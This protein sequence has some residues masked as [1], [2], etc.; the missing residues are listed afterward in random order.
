MKSRKKILMSLAIVA[1]V[2]VLAATAVVGAVSDTPYERLKA[3]VKTTMT[4]MTK[5]SGNATTVTTIILKD[6][7]TQ[8]FR[9]VES[10][11]SGGGSYEQAKTTWIGSAAAQ[12][13]YSFSSPTMNVYYDASSDTY[14]VT[15]FTDV[16]NVRPDGSYLGGSSS[17][18]S[19]FLARWNDI[20]RIADAFVG[21]LKDYVNAAELGDGGTAFSGALNETQI[22]A[23]ANAIASFAT[24]QMLLSSGVSVGGTVVQPA[25]YDASGAMKDPDGVVDPIPDTP[26]GIP[27]LAGDIFIKSVAG[28]AKTLPSG[29]L[30]DIAVS[31]VLSGTDEDGVIHDLSLDLHV[32]MSDVGTTAVAEPDLTGKKVQ[33]SESNDPYTQNKLTE[34]F[35]GTYR[36]DVVSMA[37]GKFVKIG[38]RTIVVESV[39]ADTV[40]GRYFETYVDGATHPAPLSFEFSV[41]NSGYYTLNVT[42]ADRNGTQTGNSITF[43]PSNGTASFY[44]YSSKADGTVGNGLFPRVFD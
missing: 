29:L 20:E 10:Q 23:L 12:D 44:D 32:V 9:S 6:N 3:A 37:D 1:G 16:G 13:S 25:V 31:V 27:A 11:K 28:T 42:Y 17:D 24:K 5:N 43:D 19:E 33:I 36:N 18:E 8:L 30:A 41:P 4:E 38:E 26:Y 22:P 39:T 7:G 34:A 14:Y 2:A 21:N 35:V 15:R 40:T